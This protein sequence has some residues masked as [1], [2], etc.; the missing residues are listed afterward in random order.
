M[1]DGGVANGMRLGSE[2]IYP[3]SHEL[4]ILTLIHAESSLCPEGTLVL[5]SLERGPLGP[6]G[7]TEGYNP[8]QYAAL[9]S[10]LA[11]SVVHQLE[12][13]KEARS[14][15]GYHDELHLRSVSQTQRE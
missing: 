12:R 7:N 4:R 6:Q 13:A 14:N 1:S 2:T 11:A 8:A 9:L 15:I 5:A 3:G 10:E